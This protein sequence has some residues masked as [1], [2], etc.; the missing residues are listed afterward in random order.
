V[1][2][3]G[4]KEPLIIARSLHG[5]EWVCA[6]E[7]SALTGAADLSLGRR[8]VA[9]RVGAA[10]PS[11]LGLRTADDVFM[12]AGTAAGI[13]S[14]K[15]DLDSL[16][17]AAAGLDWRG[18]LDLV[19]GVRALPESGTFDVV[20]SLD[21]K[22]GYNRFAAERCLGR[23]LAPELGFLFAE[24]VSNQAQMVRTDLTVRTFIHA[25]SALIA[26]RLGAGP[27]HRRG[28]KTS[29]G[30]GTLHPPAAAALAA[31]AAPP[32]GTLLDPFCGDGTIAIEAAIARPGLRVLASD[33]D[34]ARVASATSN[35]LLAG[36]GISVSR[37]DAGSLRCEADAVVTNPPWDR[38]IGWSGR[39]RESPGAFW[40]KVPDLLGANGTLC[41]LTDAGLEVPDL[42]AADGWA[43]AVWQRVRLAGRLADL[44]LA[45]P[46]WAK[47][48]ELPADL[49]EWRARAIAAGVISDTGF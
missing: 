47:T 32:R 41:T 14:A 2:G 6:A 4:L 33:L 29:A 42:L 44:L 36:V 23:A 13:G 39:L 46:R 15:T 7:V 45:A 38:A 40:R 43:I 12:A 25:D 34:Q 17:A 5:L 21:G 22:R 26:V 28:Y 20:V 35:A 48:P 8:E 1:T 19:R 9:F 24:R 11:L 31:I 10:G 18:V 27:L 3:A 49:R 30:A 16:G 37:A